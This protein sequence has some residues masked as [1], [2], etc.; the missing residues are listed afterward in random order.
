M[1]VNV[2]DTMTTEMIVLLTSELLASF[3]FVL[4]FLSA[5]SALIFWFTAITTGKRRLT[6]Q[7]F[8]ARSQWASVKLAAETHVVKPTKQLASTTRQ[9]SIGTC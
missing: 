4:N 1:P 9:S 2:V 5:Y 6:V 3:S 8:S 7:Y